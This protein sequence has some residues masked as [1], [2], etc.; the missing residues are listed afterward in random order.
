MR[1]SQTLISSSVDPRLTFMK[2]VG[3]EHLP[4]DFAD[5][6][7]RYKYRGSSGKVN[8][9][10]DGLPN[11]EGSARRRPASARGDIHQSRRRLHGASLRRC[12]VWPLSRGGP[13]ST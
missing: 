3:E 8:L 6:L 11:L 4:E 12:Q 9:A 13:I 2:M 7:K 5:D 1:S 10:L